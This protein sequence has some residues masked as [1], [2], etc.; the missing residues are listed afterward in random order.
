MS[1]LSYSDKT[2][3]ENAFNM[4][5]G[6]VLN[7]SD[8]TF[9][10]FF[11]TFGININDKKYCEKGTS[12]A[13]RLRTFWNIEDN[14]TVGKVLVELANKMMADNLSQSSG[15]K[16]VWMTTAGKNFFDQQ[17][18]LIQQV[19][20]IGS[21][22]LDNKNTSK[23]EYK[24]Q[25]STYCNELKIKI[26]DEIYTHIKRYLDNEDYFHAIEEAYKIVRCKLKEITTKERASEVF[27]LNA[28]NRKYYQK[29]FGEDA[30]IDS[31]KYDFFRGVGY[32]HLAVQFLRNEKAHMLAHDLDKNLAL[33]YLSLAS[34]SYDL[35]SRND[36]PEQKIPVS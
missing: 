10:D 36:T 26:R 5:T 2:I 31:P 34:L 12:K 20:K 25:T 32:L 28:E 30:S 24:I 7:F 18:I 11:A 13:N 27:N 35:I 17:R 16:A 29:L 9:S 4:H 15:V 21:K 3:L 1:D 22:L 14:T 8:N 19:E 23:T 33:H 6:Y